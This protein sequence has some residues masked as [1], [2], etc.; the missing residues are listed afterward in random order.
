M[1]L[2]KGDRKVLN[3]LLASDANVERAGVCMFMLDWAR[4]IRQIDKDGIIVAYFRKEILSK[5]IAL[6][7]KEI[8]V[9]VIYS[10][11]PQNASNVSGK[12]RRKVRRNIRSI[13]K[14][15]DF[16]VLHVNSSAAGFSSMVLIEGKKAGV[17]VRVAHSHGKNIGNGIKNLYLWYLKYLIKV[18]A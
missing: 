16:D 12:N 1:I 9:K 10:N 7:F 2:Y 8:N 13:L 6:L 4:G 18:I 5:E 17:P 3:F 11:L 14:K 15:Y